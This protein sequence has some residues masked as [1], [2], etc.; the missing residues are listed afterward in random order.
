[1]KDAAP[2]FAPKVVTLPKYLGRPQYCEISKDA[3]AAIDPDLANADV[4]FIR[5]G[6]EQCGPE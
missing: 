3:L 6:L 2:A 5:E 1:M 4:E